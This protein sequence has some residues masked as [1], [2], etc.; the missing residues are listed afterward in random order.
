MDI[1]LNAVKFHDGVP[2]HTTLDLAQRPDG[3]WHARNFDSV[4]QSTYNASK[5]AASQ[6][7]NYDTY[8]AETAVRIKLSDQEIANLAGK[9]D[10]HNMTQ[11]QYDTFLDDLIE[12]GALSRFDAMRLGHHGWRI[13]NINPDAFATG[14]AGCGTA[15]ATSADNGDG[16]PRQSLEGADGDLMRWLENMLSWQ[17]QDKA[18]NGQTAEVIKALRDIVKRMDSAHI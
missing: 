2:Y 3:T 11:D 8:E 18:G 1:T 10:P 7:R 14:G 13:L 16:G 15:Y 6:P 17:D 12:K 5:S 9:Y 4:M